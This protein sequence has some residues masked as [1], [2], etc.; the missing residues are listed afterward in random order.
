MGSKRE[1][2]QAGHNPKL[3]PK[4]TEKVKPTIGDQ[5]GINVGIISFI[6]SAIRQPKTIPINPPNPVKVVASTRNCKIMSRCVAPRALRTPIS[7]CQQ[8]ERSI[9]F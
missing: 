3:T 7:L 9:Q 1:A 6:S 4:S 2:F 5:S 8:S